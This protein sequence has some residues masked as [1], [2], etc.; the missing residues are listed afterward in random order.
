MEA[1]LKM[2]TTTTRG[3]PQ[4]AS[5]AIGTA[6]NDDRSTDVVVA[7]D[8]VR[9]L[10]S[11]GFVALQRNRTR[12]ATRIFEF[13][14]GIR[15]DRDFGVIGLALSAL[16]DNRPD[17]AEMLLATARKHMEDSD[18]LKAFHALALMLK[19]DI[20]FAKDLSCMLA[21]ESADKPISR[22]LHALSIEFSL[23]VSPLR[24]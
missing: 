6:R 1:R 13:V 15:P 7:P 2:K 21:P 14:R 10:V 18:E 19:G 11:A 17:D 23:R 16:T 12:E 4:G 3:N 8:V 24:R 9:A 22:F 5:F 20:S